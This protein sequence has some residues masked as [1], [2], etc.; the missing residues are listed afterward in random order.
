MREIVGCPEQPAYLP[1]LAYSIPPLIVSIPCPV[2]VPED[3]DRR[4]RSNAGGLEFVL[5]Q[6]ENA[7]HVHEHVHDTSTSTLTSTWTLTCTC[8][9]A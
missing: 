4:P 5:L 2:N 1:A 9:G 3:G 8:T 7:G 6:D